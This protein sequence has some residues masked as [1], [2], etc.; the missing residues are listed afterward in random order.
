M[1]SALFSNMGISV[2][3]QMREVNLEINVATL[4]SFLV[5]VIGV[6]DVNSSTLVFI[7]SGDEI[8]HLV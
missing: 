1:F 4:T 3:H 8:P 2:L 5:C 7:I 6:D